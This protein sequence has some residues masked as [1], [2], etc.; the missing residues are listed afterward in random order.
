MLEIPSKVLW[1]SAGA[2]SL[3]STTRI[4]F[5]KYTD[6]GKAINRY[7]YHN[8]KLSAQEKDEIERFCF[9]QVRAC[10]KDRYPK[11]PPFNL[12]IPIPPNMNPKISL[13]NR[14]VDLWVQTYS[15]NFLDGSKYLVRNPNTPSIKSIP[16]EDIDGRKAQAE[17]AYTL[18]EMDTKQISGFL[19]ID[20]VY[21]TGSTVRGIAHLLKNRYPEIPRF[22]I[23]LTALRENGFKEKPC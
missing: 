2:L 12:L 20:D 16:A 6:L 10:L 13:P 7:K 9:E 8:D 22:L 21:Q 15:Q 19:V 11:K 18:N 17:K 1:K 23:T 5:P 14:I 3:Y 4:P